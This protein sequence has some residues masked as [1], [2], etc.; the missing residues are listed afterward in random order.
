MSTAYHLQTDGQ[1]EALNKCVEQ[2]LHC[3]VADSPKDWVD[4]LLWAEY[5]YNTSLQTSAGMSPFQALYGRVP[6]T[7]ARYVLSGSSHELVEQ[8]FLRR[9]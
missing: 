9:D 5:W 2:Y 1:S 6:Q 4:M 7:I 3:Y 8:Y